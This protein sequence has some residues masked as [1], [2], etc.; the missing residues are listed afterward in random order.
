MMIILPNLLINVRSMPGSDGNALW[1]TEERIK[2]D[3]RWF[4]IVYAVDHF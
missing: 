1:L 3:L 4:P 2:V